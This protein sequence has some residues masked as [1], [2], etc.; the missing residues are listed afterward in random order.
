MFN[1][2]QKAFKN[3]KKYHPDR[4]SRRTLDDI[5]KERVDYNQPYMFDS[6]KFNLKQ[7]N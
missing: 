6:K 5:K 4:I 3:I 2:I 7:F 1:K